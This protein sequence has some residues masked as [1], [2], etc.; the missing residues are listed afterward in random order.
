LNRYAYVGG[1]PSNF[2]DPYGTTKCDA[3]GNNCYERVDVD[4]SLE[5]ISVDVSL[6]FNPT[7]KSVAA[8]AYSIANA[9]SYS[10]AVGLSDRVKAL[11]IT[12]CQALAAFADSLTGMSYQNFASAFQVLTPGPSAS[13]LIAAFGSAA[14]VLGTNGFAQLQPSYRNSSGNLQYYQAS[15]YGSTYRDSLDSN[16]DQGHH[17]AAFFQLG[18]N[19]GFADGGLSSVFGTALANFV[20][21]ENGLFNRGDINLAEKAF[22]LGSQVGDKRLLTSQVGQR[23]RDEI[24]AK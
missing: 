5:P 15:G 2:I 8:L 13:K 11:Q 18:F 4:G 6:G 16:S 9:R 10:I 21:L 17:F 22:A 14:G 1:D 19:L 12:D 7:F 23:I 3:N 24:C 20:E